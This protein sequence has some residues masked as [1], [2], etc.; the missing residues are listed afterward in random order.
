MNNK[1]LNN[2][3]FFVLPTNF[4]FNC[5]SNGCAYR[6]S[7]FLNYCIEKTNSYSIFKSQLQGLKMLLNMSKKCLFM[8]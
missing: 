8:Y 7:I 1:L 6:I 5:L 3:Q 4:Y 2:L